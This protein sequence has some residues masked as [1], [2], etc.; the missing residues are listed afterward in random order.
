MK[1]MMCLVLGLWVSVAAAPGALAQP[2]DN[3]LQTCLKSRLEQIRDTAIFI[4]ENAVVVERSID[5][6]PK[7]ASIL[8]GLRGR[9]TSLVERVNVTLAEPRAD[10]DLKKD[11]QKI[12]V[13]VSIL[14]SMMTRVKLAL[15]WS[16]DPA[17]SAVLA[18]MTA[19]LKVL[20]EQIPADEPTRGCEPSDNAP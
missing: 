17:A 11:L 9:A 7:A 3:P 6:N 10:D 8:A 2:A 13:D 14:G 18:A 5:S 1:W 15:M 12:S 16:R 20:R 19:R 4:E